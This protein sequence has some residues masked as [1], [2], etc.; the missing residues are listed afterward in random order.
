MTTAQVA[1]ILAVVVPA[2]ALV[3]WPVLR[4]AGGT[5]LAHRE[6]PGGRALE[7]EEEK[8]A[9]LRALKEIDFDHDAG[10]LSDDDHAGLRARYEA[11]A[12]QIV[13]ELDHLRPA[14]TPGERPAAGPAAR[15]TERPWTRHPATVA[16]G[17]VLLLLF[18]VLLGV[19]AGRFSA[20]E[21]PA[22]MAG[23]PIASAPP[24]GPGSAMS[25]GPGT[26]PAG[27][28]P[29][30]PLAPEILAGMLQAARQSLAAGRY[31]EAIAAYQA[32]LKR[33]ERNV[34]AMTHLA[35]IVAIGGHADS[36]LETWAKALTL[37]PDYPPAYLYRGQVLYEVKQDYAG[38]VR[39]WE[40]FVKLVPA[41]AD[42]D[43]VAAML[44]DARQKRGPR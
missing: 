43:R 24:P 28:D 38:A 22:S 34:D 25:P 11:R 41:G 7:L 29:A 35:L 17:A 18:G 37:D 4:G 27:G 1:T 40:R 19:N 16:T 13:T 31:Q 10:H 36:A 20:P 12:A 5:G 8:T 26:P 15:P 2:L 9:I 32:V 33:D 6:M 3:L 39:D 44:T 14:T 21:P 23:P 42:H 30:R